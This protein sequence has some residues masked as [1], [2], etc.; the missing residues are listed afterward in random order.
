MGCPVCVG[1]QHIYGNLRTNSCVYMSMASKINTHSQLAYPACHALSRTKY[2]VYNIIDY[3][4][5]ISINSVLSMCIYTYV[6]I[7]FYTS[8]YIEKQLEVW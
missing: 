7:A 8:T 2:T 5:Q 4:D 1:M 3:R 6:G